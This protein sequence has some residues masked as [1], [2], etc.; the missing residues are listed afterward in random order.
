MCGGQG[1]TSVVTSLLPPCWSPGSNSCHDWWLVSLST[2]PLGTH[3]SKKME[4]TEKSLGSFYPFNYFSYFQFA[5][6]LSFPV[7]CII[8]RLRSTSHSRLGHLSPNRYYQ[9]LR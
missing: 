1:E 3:T 7:A 9:L 5:Q 8:A 4:S 2:E 6:I